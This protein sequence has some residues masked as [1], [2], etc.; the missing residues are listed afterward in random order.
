MRSRARI[1]RIAY[2]GVGAS[3][4][5]AVIPCTFGIAHGIVFGD[6]SRQDS[7]AQ[8]MQ[9]CKIL[10]CGEKS[11][12]Y[13]YLN[14]SPRHEKTNGLQ[15]GQLP[16][17][18]KNLPPMKESRAYLLGWLMGYFA[19]DG[20]L[21]KKGCT[22]SSVKR[23]NLERVRDVCAVLGIHSSPITSTWRQGYLDH[24]GELFSVHLNA[25][26]LPDCF[27]IRSKHQ[28]TYKR[29]YENCA[30]KHVGSWRVQSVE[31][32]DR[33]EEVYCVTVPEAHLFALED[34]LKVRNC[35]GFCVKAGQAHFK[36]LLETR[37]EV[38]DMHER[39]EQRLI[40]KLG[41]NHKGFIK[42]QRNNVIHY[43]TMRQFREL[44]ES[45]RVEVDKLDVG[46]CGCFSD[47]DDSEIEGKTCAR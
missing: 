34:F 8:P 43:Y 31:E 9:P 12:L 27:F 38:Y 35:G 19:T 16:R 5:S 15:V 23:R 33:V 20:S 4:K 24:L 6:G 39:A 14:G 32:T 13:K 17:H 26:S 7:E 47:F 40:R 3:V 42:I 1:D 11:E 36:H 45:R 21:D 2:Q 44:L 46:G 10:L 28:E 25:E 22:I 37:P 30:D 41:L 29:F 18:Y